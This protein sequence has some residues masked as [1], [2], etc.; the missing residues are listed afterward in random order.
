MSAAIPD[1]VSRYS[2]ASG[3]PGCCAIF[4]P[5]FPFRG[6]PEPQAAPHGGFLFAPLAQQRHPP[7]RCICLP[8]RDVLQVKTFAHFLRTVFYAADS[9]VGPSGVQ[10][11]D[12]VVKRYHCALVL[13]RSKPSTIA[14]R[15]ISRSKSRF[16]THTHTHKHNTP[17]HNT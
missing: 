17:Q 4:E 11:G 14:K 13:R 15:Q 7:W 6:L 8:S 16:L 10:Q 12:A 2:K 1:L 9:M 5:G 3:R